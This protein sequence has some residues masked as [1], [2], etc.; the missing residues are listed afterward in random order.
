MSRF[1]RRPIPIPQDVEVDISGDIVRVSGPRGEVSRRLFDRR[2]R[3]EKSGKEL[4]VHVIGESESAM[5]GT[6]WR[7]LRGMVVGVSEG[8]SIVLEL[9]GVGYRSSLE[10]DT[11][12][13]LQLGFSHPIRYTLPSGVSASSSSPTEIVLTGVDKV[14][15]GQVAADIRSCRPPEPYK[16]KGVRY[17]GE[18]ISLKEMRKDKKK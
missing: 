3:I 12:V 13:V 10:G 16:G 15:V 17:R 8:V 5:A 6:Y 1:V 14:L 4:W 7:T 2:A 11:T 18:K 9:V